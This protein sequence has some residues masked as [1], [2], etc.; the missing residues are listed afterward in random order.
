MDTVIGGLLVQV[1]HLPA[2]FSLVKH[3]ALLNP[4]E[5]LNIGKHKGFPCVVVSNRCKAAEA[6]QRKSVIDGGCQGKLALMGGSA[7]FNVYRR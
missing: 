4:S 6:G 7:R 3:F 5:F 1:T 2:F